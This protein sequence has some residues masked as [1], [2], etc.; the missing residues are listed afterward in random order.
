MHYLGILPLPYLSSSKNLCI[1]TYMHYYLMRYEIVD[2][3]C[4]AR[5]GRLSYNN[6]F[7]VVA[8][9]IENSGRVTRYFLFQRDAAAPVCQVKQPNTL[10]VDLN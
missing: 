2:C 8:L 9:Y 1:M 5:L 3:T 4:A 10:S 7:I 6:P